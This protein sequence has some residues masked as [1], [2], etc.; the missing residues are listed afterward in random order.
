MFRKKLDTLLNEEIVTLLKNNNDLREKLEERAIDNAVF[1]LEDYLEGM[2]NGAADYS[3]SYGYSYGDYFTIKN[4]DGFLEWADGVQN[5]YCFYS[6][7]DWETIKEL[8]KVN[9]TYKHCFELWHYGHSCYTG[10]NG[11]IADKDFYNVENKFTELGDKA[12]KLTLAQL[13]SEFDYWLD[14]IHTTTWYLGLW[15]YFDMVYDYDTSNYFTDG[16][17]TNIYEYDPGV[18]KPRRAVWVPAH[19]EYRPGAYEPESKELVI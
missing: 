7:D 8:E 4:V 6:D 18:Y 13:R 16:N 17:L 9:E 11:N 19:L 14:G 2:P 1:W 15:E 5:D 10:K 3:I 12:A